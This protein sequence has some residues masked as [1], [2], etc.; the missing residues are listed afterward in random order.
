MLFNC[1]SLR[2]LHKNIDGLNDYIEIKDCEVYSL[3]W[4]IKTDRNKLYI[5]TL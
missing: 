1:S 2:K 3:E 4:R 5:L